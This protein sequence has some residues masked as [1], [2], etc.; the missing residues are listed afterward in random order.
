MTVYVDTARHPFR[1]YIMC[2]MIADTLDE[3]HTMADK[4]GMERRWFQAPPKASHPHYDIP[5]TKRARALSFGAQEICQRGGLHY[6]AQL[7][8]EWAQ[9]ENDN[10]RCEKYRRTIART[11][12][13]ASGYASEVSR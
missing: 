9:G 2:H 7:G 13:Y 10:A 1:G 5:E 11:Q 12:S 8:L 3:L 6:A 4:I